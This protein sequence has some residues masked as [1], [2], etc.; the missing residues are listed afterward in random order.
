MVFPPS[1]G[2]CKASSE[3]FSGCL[4]CASRYVSSHGGGSHVE[5]TGNWM[6]ISWKF[7]EIPEVLRPSNFETHKILMFPSTTHTHTPANVHGYVL[8]QLLWNT[9]LR[10]SNRSSTCFSCVNQ[11][12]SLV[13]RD[14]HVAEM[15]QHLQG[16]HRHR[17]SGRAQE[18]DDVK[19]EPW[20]LQKRHRNR[21]LRFK[22]LYLPKDIWV[23]GWFSNIR[24]SRS[25]NW[26]FSSPFWKHTQSV[27]KKRRS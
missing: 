13:F 16:K 1:R 4:G 14:G 20:S 3:E 24:D 17:M 25:K 18:D 8:L 2:S 23:H 9:Q 12:P 27:D 22:T 21:V 15:S 26:C 10:V 11:T 6:I 7:H 5:S 19:P